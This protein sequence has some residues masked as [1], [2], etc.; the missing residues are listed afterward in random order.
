[1]PLGT[2][3]FIFYALVIEMN[4]AIR[5]ISKGLVAKN[6]TEN[7]NSLH[8]FPLELL[9]LMDGELNTQDVE[10]KATGM[11]EDGTLYNVDI[12]LGTTIKADWLGDS[13]NRNTAPDMRTGM[14]VW[15]WQAGDSDSYYWSNIGRDENLKRLERVIW[16]WG[17]FPEIDDEDIG[18]DNQYWLEVNTYDGLVTFKTSQRNGEFTRYTGQFNTRDGVVTL[19][20]ELGNVIQLNSK[21]TVLHLLNADGSKVVLSKKDI[22]IHADENVTVTT[23]KM[24]VTCQTSFTLDS[25]MVDFV[26]DT[27]NVEAKTG[28]NFITPKITYS[29][30]LEGPTLNT[31]VLTATTS[32]SVG[33]VTS[34]GGNVNAPGVL[35]GGSLDA[36]HSH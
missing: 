29:A 8:I 18:P 36:P 34:A 35:K 28:V 27:F 22:E 15:L 4:S 19:Q 1:M 10:S 12:R 11:N 2:R 5:I 6:K 30:V 9:N 24:S 25:P 7:A 23:D 3:C 26:C 16:R 33:G 13:G 21:D 20:D 32:G 31:E 14:Q 17:A